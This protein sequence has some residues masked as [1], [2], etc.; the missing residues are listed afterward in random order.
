MN[1]KGALPPRGP[2]PPR[3][4]AH[5]QHN[6]PDA[7]A[8]ATHTQ[9][10]VSPGSV[11]IPRCAPRVV[12]TPADHTSRAALPACTC[13]APA[14]ALRLSPC[15]RRTSARK[16]PRRS[17]PC[18]SNP[19]PVASSPLG[20]AVPSFAVPVQASKA[21]STSTASRQRQLQAWSVDGAGRAFAR[22]QRPFE[23]FPCRSL[24]YTH[25]QPCIY[26]HSHTH[27]HVCTHTSCQSS[28]YVHTHTSPTG[29]FSHRHLNHYSCEHATAPPLKQ[30]R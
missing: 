3:A 15:P 20:P 11:P 28:N 30:A 13:A 12:H 14:P 27:T 24:D 8:R 19:V 21:T 18:C 10:H 29:M 9:L 23:R 7:P 6:T 26:T 22:G 17:N 2:R 5:R 1:T 25:S 16:R 4:R